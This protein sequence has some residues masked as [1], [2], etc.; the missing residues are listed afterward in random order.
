MQAEK[1]VW[2]AGAQF[3]VDAKTAVDTIHDIQQSLGKD[4]ITAKE[5]LDASRNDDAP[6]HSCFEWD[7]TIA[8]EKYR[9]EQARHIINSIEIR[10]VDAD[11]PAHLKQ[12]RY[13]VNTTCVTPK[14]QQGQFA[15][16]NVA[17]TNNNYRVAVLKN[18]LCELR[19]FQNKYS[20][21]QEL[22]GVI[23]AIDDF[24]DTF[25]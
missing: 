10:F 24:G 22:S 11:N 14:A 8:A 12:T 23:K 4:T 20:S 1:F 15:T 9:V 6:L 17:F 2:K 18:A 16:I 21:Y 7:D 19:A 13:L 25:K 3:P 5:L